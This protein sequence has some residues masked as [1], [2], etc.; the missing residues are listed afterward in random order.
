MSRITT[1]PAVSDDLPAVVEMAHGLAA[2]HGDAATLT[3]ETL[4]RD[5]LGA[6]PWITL[7]VAEAR[8]ALIGYAALCPLV[9]VQYGVR[10]MDMHHL[11]VRAEAR[12]TGAGH[13]LIAA[14]VQVSKA[15]GCRYLAVGTH[16]DNTAAQGFYERAG[17]SRTTGGPRFR[18]K[19]EEAD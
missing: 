13:A 14:S 5:A 11:F 9:Q 12:G 18:L 7:L 16:P 1:R 8:G 6:P 17:F 2:F 10:G 19:L 15:Q 3:V 4:T